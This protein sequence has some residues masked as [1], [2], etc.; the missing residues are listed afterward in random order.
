MIP[1][2]ME[3]YEKVVVA[4]MRQLNAGLSMVMRMY[5]PTDVLVL[6]NVVQFMQDR[7]FAMKP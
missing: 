5:D 1:F 3:D 2:L 4:D 6:Y 7:D